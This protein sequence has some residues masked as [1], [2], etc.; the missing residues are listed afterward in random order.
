MSYGEDNR[1]PTCQNLPET[2]GAPQ[3]SPREQYTDPAGDAAESATNPATRDGCPG[4]S[5]AL[6]AELAGSSGTRATTAPAWVHR[7]QPYAQA[8]WPAHAGEG[9]RA[10]PT[11][12][13]VIPNADTAGQPYRVIGPVIANS[14]WTPPGAVSPTGYHRQ[15]CASD[16]T[17]LDWSIGTDAD[18]RV[19]AAADVDRARIDCTGAPAPAERGSATGDVRARYRE[20]ATCTEHE[21]AEGAGYEDFAEVR[22]A[23][24]L[25]LGEVEEARVRYAL[26]AWRRDTTREKRDQLQARTEAARAALWDVVRR[27]LEQECAALRADAERYHWLRARLGVI[28]SS[29]PGDGRDHIGLFSLTEQGNDRTWLST[30][31]GAPEVER[32]DAHGQR[33]D[34]FIDAARAA[35]PAREDDA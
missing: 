28:R 32:P 31:A 22:R 4:A 21:E 27:A 17:R 30:Q 20:D 33:M 35:R 1:Q 10:T 26:R 24:E 14:A 23:V 6:A 7:I 15:A 25:A 18:G 19:A 34:E 3:C 16:G 13:D 29:M 8:Q 5:A 2:G 9:V 12:P 11:P